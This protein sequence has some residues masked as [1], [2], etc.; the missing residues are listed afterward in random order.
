MN[1]GVRGSSGNRSVGGGEVLGPLTGCI[2]SGPEFQLEESA[3]PHLV[4]RRVDV[5]APAPHVRH[6]TASPDHLEE[7]G[8]R[9]S[10]PA[11]GHRVNSRPDGKTVKLSDFKGRKVVVYFYPKA[12]TPGCTTQSCALR[13]AEPD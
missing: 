2:A 6:A 3:S 12:D 13:D 4:G 9:S 8:W 5:R 10:P 7:L 11:T 1:R